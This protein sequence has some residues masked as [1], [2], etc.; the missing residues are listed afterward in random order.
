[1]NRDFNQAHRKSTTSTKSSRAKWG[2]PILTGYRLRE[3]RV[4]F[5][6]IQQNR[7]ELVNIAINLLKII[8]RRL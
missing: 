1:M 8:S 5:N 7:E 2:S 4:P 6:I 3:K